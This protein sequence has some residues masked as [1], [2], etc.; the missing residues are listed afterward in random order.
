MRVNGASTHPL[1]RCGL[2]GIPSRDGLI[3]KEQPEGPVSANPYHDVWLDPDPDATK[4]KVVTAPMTSELK[5]ILEQ[6][7]MGSLRQTCPFGDFA[8]QMAKLDAENLER[9]NGVAYE[10]PLE[11]PKP[12]GLFGAL[13]QAVFGPDQR[14]P[15]AWLLVDG[16]PI[17]DYNIAQQN[18]PPRARLES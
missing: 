7:I 17:C 6:T 3:A 1:A 8:I 5:G 12:R 16:Q 4:F 10:V 14:A 15:E 2:V 9:A 13:K 11:Q 18:L